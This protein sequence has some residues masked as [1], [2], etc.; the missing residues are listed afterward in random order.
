MITI[1]ELRI[2]W[3]FLLG[4]NLTKAEVQDL[5]SKFDINGSGDI[6]YAEWLKTYDDEEWRLEF[7]K[8]LDR[9]GKG[10]ISVSE[11]R[12]YMIQRPKHRKS[13]CFDTIH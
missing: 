11:M 13:Q 7:Y 6:N 12:A 4:I 10:F 3:E 9:D 5:F 1:E 2:R 8:L